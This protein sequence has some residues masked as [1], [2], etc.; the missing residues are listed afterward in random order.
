MN[1]D[2]LVNNL[3]HYNS[4][5]EFYKQYYYAKQQPYSLDKFLTELDFDFVKRNHLIIPEIA[6]T[7]P[8]R[9]EDSFFFGKN[10]NASILVLRH[11]RFSPAIEHSHTFFEL[12]YVYDGT[13]IH[14]IDNQTVI[15][16]KGDICIIPPGVTHSVSV[17]DDSIIFNCIIRKATLHNV[18]FN[19][20]RNTNILSAFFLNNIYSEKGSTYIVFH[21]GNDNEIRNSF[22]YMYW[23]TV[24]ESLYWDQ[25]IGFTLML[26]FGILIRNY[27]KSVELPSPANKSD[28]KRYEILQYMQD[29]FA[30]ISLDDLASYF[31]YTPEYMSKLIKKVFGKNYTYILQDIRLEKA[32]ILL[33]DTNLSISNISNQ[34][35]YENTESF[36]RSFKK[37][38]HMTPTEYRKSGYTL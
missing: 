10:P 1:F 37:K 24:N 13:C 28:I 26:T 17:F 22:L 19:F 27:D 4:D 31:H 18:F 8:P 32:K 14:T 20:L 7:I 11:N 9:Y 25:M 35:G 33:Y 34:I 3:Y 36:I 21:T 15:L 2:T 29:N 16:K 12:L 30:S 6:S 38:N 5:E 23:E